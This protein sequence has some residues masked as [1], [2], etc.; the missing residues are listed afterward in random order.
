M[1]RT[2]LLLLAFLLFL[3]C[4][5]VCADLNFR[6]IGEELEISLMT[7]NLNPLDLEPELFLCDDSCHPLKVK[8][9]TYSHG[10]MNFFTLPDERGNFLLKIYLKDNN[11]TAYYEK[12]IKVSKVYANEETELKKA[13]MTANIVN[14][15]SSPIFLFG[16][17]GFFV[18]F[19]IFKT[20]D[21]GNQRRF[22]NFPGSGIKVLFAFLISF[23]FLSSFTHEFFHIL[24]AGFFSCPAVLDSFIPLLTPT[25]VSLNL[26][27]ITPLQSIL[28]LGA[29]VVGNIFLGFGL[30]FLSKIRDSRLI[31]SISLAFFFSSFFYLFYT[32]GDIHNIIR[33]VGMDINQI[34]LNLAGIGLISLSLWLFLN[35]KSGTY[36]RYHK[37]I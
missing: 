33:I 22:I 21:L 2:P 30:L 31:S 13:G 25:S 6:D 15:S 27:N 16:L 11:K 17:L 20:K 14:N 26:C 34:F 23:V 10:H 35:Q 9:F 37:N 12:N 29:G 32:T 18:L 8:S 24:T 3:P 5:P 1:R 28:I 7:G 4:S 36:P 19:S